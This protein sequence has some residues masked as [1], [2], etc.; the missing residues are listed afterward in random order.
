M[1]SRFR[2]FR[3]PIIGSEDTI[4][5]IIK[6]AVCLHNYVKT[7]D[8][9]LNLANRKYCSVGY[10]DSEDEDGVLN[11]GEWRSSTNSGLNNVGQTAFNMYS[12]EA[13]NIRERFSYY[14]NNNGAVP[15]QLRSVT[16]L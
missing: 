15:W 4:E 14:F 1:A 5:R 6:A 8:D 13:A 2:I 16:A 10:A 12:R 7:E 11:P 9:S 3:R